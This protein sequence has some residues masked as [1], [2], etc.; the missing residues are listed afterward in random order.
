MKLV[1]YSVGPIC[2]APELFQCKIHIFTAKLSFSL[3]ML[4]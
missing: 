4:S 3:G 1:Q 2:K